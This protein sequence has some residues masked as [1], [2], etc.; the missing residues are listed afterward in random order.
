[1]VSP[2][3]I[4]SY[5]RRFIFDNSLVFYAPL[6]HP[7]LTGSPFLSKDLN[8]V[9]CAVTGATWGIQGRNFDGTDDYIAI[10]RHA[11]FTQTTAL[12]VMF[13]T[14]VDD[15]T[16]YQVVFAFGAF[17]PNTNTGDVRVQA[18]NFDTYYNRLAGEVSGKLGTTV[19][20]TAFWY[21]VT[22]VLQTSQFPLLY[23]NGV[24]EGA[25]TG[26]TQALG[27]VNWDLQIAKTPYSVADEF[28][29]GTIGEVW[30]YNRVLTALEIQH[31]YLATKWRYQ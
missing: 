18:N 21:H 24:A 3:K 26:T 30:D 8:A 2:L 4:G 7:E 12:T 27:G 31:N 15:K 9:S 5:G 17:S 1:M 10:T 13:W 23:I 14:K 11:S 25:E 19:I 29:D 16:A 20:N 28:Y 22:V 6:W